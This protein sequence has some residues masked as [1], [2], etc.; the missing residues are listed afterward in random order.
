MRYLYTP[1]VVFTTFLSGC[2]GLTKDD[3]NSNDFQKIT[4][5]YVADGAAGLKA[6]YFKKQATDTQGIDAFNIKVSQKLGTRIDASL[7]TYALNNSTPPYPGTGTTHF[8]IRWSGY[9]VAPRSGNYMLCTCADDGARIVLDGNRI[10]PAAAYGSQAARFWGSDP[11]AME[12]GKR[13]PIRVDYF[14]NTGEGR[15]QLYWVFNPSDNNY[16]NHCYG[17][18]AAG[19]RSNACG[20]GQ[21][22]SPELVAISQ[23]NLVPAGSEVENSV[24]DCNSTRVQLSEADKANPADPFVQKAIS[25]FDKLG[26][27]QTNVYD[28]RVK[29]VAQLLQN[30]KKKEAAQLVTN[31]PEFYEKTVYRMAAKMSTRERSP[32]AALNDYIATFVG[33]VRDRIDARQLLTGNFLYRGKEILFSSD[34]AMYD[35]NALVS[36]NEHYNQLAGTG[37]PLMCSLEKMDRF[38]LGSLPK[39]FEQ[40]ISTANA[41][42]MTLNPEPAGL[43]T[44][45]AWS[46]AHYIAGTNRR[47]V[48]I[49]FEDFLCAPLES[50][51]TVEAS[52]EMVGR[53]VERFPNGPASNAEYQTQCKSCHANLDSLRPAFSKLSF[54]NGFLKYAPFYVANNRK[55]LTQNDEEPAR[56]KVSPANRDYSVTTQT[57]VG[58]I[59]VSWKLNHN[60]NYPDGYFISDSRFENLFSQTTIGSRFGWSETSGN[61]VREFGRMIAKTQAFPRCMAKKVYKEVCRTDPFSATF[62]V[63]LSTWLDQMG[64]QFAQNGFDLLDLFQTLGVSCL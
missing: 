43:M 15:F 53:D 36:S 50:I 23:N 16:E 59:P 18:N 25:L 31:D 34:K 64:D 47:P 41:A 19:E 42:D 28:S 32:A 3:G 46:Q 13:I 48:Q 21:T 8:A 55:N 40:K 56:M 20:N 24:A 60:V 2:L 63:E 14:Q 39:N 37:V 35:R 44:S 62:P 10:L 33:V 45:R 12:A 1:A 54:E 26:S 17:T 57:A 30:N 52:D 58:Y 49:A 22:L 11:I 27:I 9:L 51:R 5:S 6:E 38:S 7:S 4:Q 29:E 61:G